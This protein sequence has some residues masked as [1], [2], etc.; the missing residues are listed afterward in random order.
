MISQYQPG[1]TGSSRLFELDHYRQE[2]RT[3]R[4]NQGVFDLLY[5]PLQKTTF[6]IFDARI[7]QRSIFR[8]SKAE[9]G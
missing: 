6:K 3:K 8:V 2:I 5:S 4:L 7:Y 1:G 9:D